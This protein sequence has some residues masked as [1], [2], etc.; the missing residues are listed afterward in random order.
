[1]RALIVDDV[2]SCRKMLV[3]ILGQYGETVEAE[4]G[5]TALALF[6]KSFHSNPF[7]LICLDIVMPGKDGMIVLKEIREYEWTMYFHEYKKKRVNIIMLTG[8]EDM[9]KLLSSFSHG[10]LG[11]LIKPLEVSDLMEKLYYHKLI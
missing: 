11:Y 10:V 6:K 7:N 1:M 8:E 5:E 2:M 4:D 3:Q 9:C